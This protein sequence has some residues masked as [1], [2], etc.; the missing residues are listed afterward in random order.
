MLL[1]S[2]TYK[3]PM[4]QKNPTLLY[5]VP[6]NSTGKNFVTNVFSFLPVEFIAKYFKE[7]LTPEMEVIYY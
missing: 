5:K 3:L 1:I 2:R 7:Y 6:S 4:R